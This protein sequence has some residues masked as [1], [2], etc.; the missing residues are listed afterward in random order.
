MIDSLELA[1]LKQAKRQ[2]L[3]AIDQLDKNANAGQ[4]RRWFGRLQ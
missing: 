1:L 2:S 3:D 4:P